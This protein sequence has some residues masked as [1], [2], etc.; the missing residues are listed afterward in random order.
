MKGKIHEFLF[1]F[2]TNWY[3]ILQYIFLGLCIGAA[4]WSDITTTVI[5]MGIVVL[6][7]SIINL[8]SEKEKKQTQ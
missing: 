6:F 5:F 1:T 2:P 7:G 8:I 4:Y 3:T